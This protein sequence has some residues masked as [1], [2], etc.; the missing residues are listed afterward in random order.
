MVLAALQA[1]AMRSG[2]TIDEIAPQRERE[3]RDDDTPT[4]SALDA[5][6]PADR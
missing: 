4:T 3:A 5:V 2:S 1:R 6:N